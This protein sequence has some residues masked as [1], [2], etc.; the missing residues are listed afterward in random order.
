VQIVMILFAGYIMGISFSLGFLLLW[1]L[2][3][4]ALSVVY[5]FWIRKKSDL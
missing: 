5:F 2:L 1:I 4:V 3:F